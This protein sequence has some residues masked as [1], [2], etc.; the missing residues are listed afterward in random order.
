MNTDWNLDNIYKS[1]DSTEFKKDLIKYQKAIENLNQWCKEN[2]ADISRTQ[3]KLEK[4]IEL[5]NSLLEFEK[6]GM[7][8][9]LALAAD[10]TNSQL[11]KALDT[12]EALEAD[13]AY[14]NTMLIEFLKQ[15]KDIDK[16]IEN[17]EIL[18]E[19]RFFITEKS[20]MAHHC[21]SHEQEE[22]IAKMKNTG[23]NMWEKLWDQLSSTLEC[24]FRG[25]KHP[26]SVIRNMAYS[27]DFA[28][29]KDAYEAEINSYKKIELSA[30]FCLNGI[31]GQ[32]ITT[33]KLHN[34]SSPL[35]QTLENS[36]IDSSILNA[37]FSAIN[38]KLPELRKYFT[39][40]SQYLGG[41]GSLA[42]YD[43]FA[44]V[45]KS[46]L[47]YTLEEA[48]DFVLKCF[49]GFSKDLGDFATYA[50][51]NRW[52]DL[53]PKKGKVGGA[54]CETIH[55]I[56]ESR[57]LTNFGGTFNDVVTIAHE[58]GHAFHNTRLFHLSQ[59]NSFYPMPIAE[60]ASNFCET[61]V[62]NEALKNADKNS[63]LIIRENDLQGA[64]QCI[65]DIYSRFLFEDSVF[66]A[67][68]KG[69]LS[70]EEYCN[71]M[72]EAQKKAYGKGLDEKYLHPYMWVCK[73]HYYDADFNYYNFPYAFGL[74]LAKSLY[75]LYIKDKESFIPL[76][77]K[78][79]SASSTM[80]LKDVAKISGFDITSEDFWLKG[81]E[82]I[83]KEIEEF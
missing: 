72:T 21:L 67:R 56:K 49:Y 53:L 20:A 19:H 39:K 41:S 13:T 65:I 50:F 17:S 38:K 25:E 79:L 43:L 80:A 44:P 57:I 4:Y 78:F 69:S 61:I 74:L 46:D 52:L 63:A 64:T 33:S 35:E 18:K 76:Y 3:E 60:T 12:I 75:S 29:R 10:T 58:L 26:L 14:E 36:R 2:F 54:F 23:S 40:K 77:D 37:M 82:Q 68:E 24:D 27:E 83:E 45:G 70:P 34:Y 15:V 51:E 62:V 11:A 81:L 32:V 22:I 42:F 6:L 7:Y 59:I 8:I 47:K 16:L 28:V 30:A 71:L 73:P 66:K 55:S 31:K 9:N 1:A 48:K 5:K